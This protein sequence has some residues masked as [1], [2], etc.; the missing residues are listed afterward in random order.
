MKFTEYQ[1]SANHL[2]TIC[3][4]CCSTTEPEFKACSI[5]ASI[6][7]ALFDIL[8]SSL[9]TE[10]LPPRR[11]MTKAAWLLVRLKQLQDLISGHLVSLDVEPVTLLI[12]VCCRSSFVSLWQLFV[13]KIRVILA[14]KKR[15][16][17]D[18]WTQT[19]LTALREMTSS[20][21]PID[22]KLSC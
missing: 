10:N 1:I 7:V 3:R 18:A 6:G 13:L 19:K 9:A 21:K 16:I 5:A 20:L 2:L 12:F 8:Y 22:F 17:N 4:L 11:T 14:T 15:K